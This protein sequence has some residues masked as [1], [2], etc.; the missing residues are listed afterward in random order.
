MD[1]ESNAYRY[2]LAELVKENKCQ[3]LLIDDAVKRILHKKI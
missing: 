2:H 1:M 3:L